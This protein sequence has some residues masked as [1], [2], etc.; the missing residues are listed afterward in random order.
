MM[1]HK[2]EYVRPGARSSRRRPSPGQVGNP[3]LRRVG[4][5]GA[6]AAGRRPWST[7]GA[8]PGL[9]WVE[10][11]DQNRSPSGTAP[12]FWNDSFASLPVN[13]PPLAAKQR[14]VPHPATVSCTGRCRASR[15][16]PCGDS[17]ARSRRCP[18]GWRAARIHTPGVSS[19]PRSV[20]GQ[21][22]SRA[23]RD[24]PSEFEVARSTTVLIEGPTTLLEWACGGRGKWAGPRKPVQL[25]VLSAIHMR[26]VV[27]RAVRPRSP[28]GVAR[29]GG[30]CGAPNAARGPARRSV[31]VTS[32]PESS[33][34]GAGAE[35]PAAC[36]RFRGRRQCALWHRVPSFNSTRTVLDPSRLRR[37]GPAGSARRENEPPGRSRCLESRLQPQKARKRTL[38]PD[39]RVPF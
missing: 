3:A 38:E 28:S 4:I 39:E 22:P 29:P 36:T 17:E 25:T 13:R 19:P 21:T 18:A 1:P 30:A 11:H 2:D 16:A 32:L 8:G 6:R 20:P 23:F 27:G 14:E 35:W 37:A 12:A 7:L 33:V 24:R 26:P 5:G 31:S 15:L 34:P 9:R 10:G